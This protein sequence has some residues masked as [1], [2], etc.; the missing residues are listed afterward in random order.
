VRQLGLNID[1]RGL[2]LGCHIKKREDQKKRKYLY[3]GE[4]NETDKHE[5][6]SEI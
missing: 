6:E 3:Y 1:H 5:E 2:S 4:D